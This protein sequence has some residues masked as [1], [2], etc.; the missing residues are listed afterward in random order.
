MGVVRL[1]ASA[2]GRAFLV[3]SLIGF[4]VALMVPPGSWAIYVQM[5]LSYHL[6][7]GWLIISDEN[8]TGFSLPILSTVFTHMC[9]L[10]VLISL[11][12]LRHSI[13]FFNYLRFGA[14]FLASYECQWLFRSAGNR[15]I[16]EI[17]TPAVAQD[18]LKEPA[19]APAMQ[20]VTVGMDDDHEAWL[21]HLTHR[22]PGDIRRGLT[23]KEEHDRFMR[24]RAISRAG[25]EATK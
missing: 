1:L 20:L 8:T 22:K 18:A 25:N 10:A 21:H 16:S 12:A 15:E 11:P 19:P 4:L 14:T 13:P 17:V 5:L 23:L 3:C 7:L 9:C 6:Y 24:A 2:N